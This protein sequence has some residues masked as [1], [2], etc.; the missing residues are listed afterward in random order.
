MPGFVIYMGVD[1]HCRRNMCMAKDHLGVPR[2][3][4]ELFQQRGR[5]VPEIMNLDQA[6]LVIVADTAERARSLRD[7]EPPLLHHV[8]RIARSPRRLETPPASE[9]HP[10]RHRDRG[11]LEVSMG[12]IADPPRGGYQAPLMAV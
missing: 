11:S 12:M 4:V 6:D 10:A 7:Q 9:V 1:L 8:A 3:D 5:R 2:R